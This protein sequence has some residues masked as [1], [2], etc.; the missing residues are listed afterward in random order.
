MRIDYDR[1]KAV[2][3]A[4]KW[5]LSKN[6]AYFYFDGLGGDC[7]NFVSQSLLA[8]GA[9]MN[10][11]KDTGWYYRS[12]KDRSAAWSGV[13]YF[14]RFLIGN[15]KTGPYA[16][17]LPLERAEP[18]DVIQLNFDG[19]KYTHTLLVL[20]V[21]T[22]PAPENILIATHSFAS[23]DRPLSTYL[24]KKYRLLHIEGIR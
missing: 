18:G 9:V 13:E 15:K 16:K 21:G 22:E 12:V 2:A 23:L 1:E 17:E 20:S 10:F 3:Y 14:Y 6:P 4:S 11:A 19:V 5:A 7:T 24:Y 8:G